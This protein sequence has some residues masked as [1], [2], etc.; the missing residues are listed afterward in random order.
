MLFQLTSVKQLEKDWGW[1][2]VGPIYMIS[3]ITGFIFGGSFAPERAPSVGCSGSL[4]GIF[5]CLLLDLLQHWKLLRS[6]WCALFR[7][8]LIFIVSFAI[9][10]LPQIDNFAHVGGF[11]GG[12]LAGLLFMPTISFGGKFGKLVK[13]GVFKLAGAVLLIL[14]LWFLLTGFYN[15]DASQ[16]CTW[17]KYI[18]C[19]PIGGIFECEVGVTK[20]VTTKSTNGTTTSFSR[21]VF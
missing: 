1:W 7:M 12:L 17:C 20:V 15:N 3:G 19:L 5:A 2:R 21:S 18:D 4:F 13:R 14:L 16:K 6:P 8:L 9:G 11:I 10:L